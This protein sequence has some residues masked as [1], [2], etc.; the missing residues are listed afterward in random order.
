M[1]YLSVEGLSKTFGSKL[2][3][4]KINFGIN[5]GQRVALVA[6]NGAGKSTLLKIIMGKEIPDEGTVTLRK[7]ISLAYLDQQPQFIE[8]SSIADAIYQTNNPVLTAVKNYELAIAAYE[9]DSGPANEKKLELASAE[10]ENLNAWDHDARVKEVLSRLNIN[11][12]ERKISSLSGGQKKRLALA[13]LLI[14]TPDLLILDEPTNHLDIEMIEWLEN[15]LVSNNMTLLLVTHDRYFLDAVC[16]EIIEI[17]NGKLYHYAGDFQ[18]YVEKKAEREQ[19]ESSEI[20]KAKNLYKRE[21]EWIRKMPRARTVKSKSR[22]DA[23]DDIKEKAFSKRKE[24]K[25]TL[26]VKMSRLGSKIIELTKVHKKYG[27]Q[28]IV[29][30]FSYVF[31]TGEKI[32]IIGKNGVGKTTLI[33]MITGVEQVDSGKIQTGDTIIF[34]H[35]SQDG[36]K[37]PEDKRVIEVIKDIADYIPLS[38]GS[39]LSAAQILQR[40]MFPPDVQYSFVSKLSGGEKRRLYLLTVLMK[41]PN[42]LILDEPTNDLDLMTMNTLED[43]LLGFKGC[44]LIVTHDRFFMDKLVDHLFVFEGDGVIRDFPGHYTDYREKLAEEKKA[45]K[46]LPKE[47]EKPIIVETP[48]LAPQPEKPKRQLSFKEKHEFE[49][50]EKELPKLE[51]EKKSLDEK[52]AIGS[53][54]SNDIMQWSTRIGIVIQEI[55]EKTMRWLELS[56]LI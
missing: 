9:Q 31:K 25:I 15:Y 52:L 6:R 56:E 23:F 32:G 21:L 54:N 8:T 34:G 1:N 17:D 46:N 53:S 7:D 35:Y 22:I 44:V 4:N 26:D 13:T 49:Q 5:H 19:I 50:L 41:N 16:S 30:D 42:F 24:E 28:K 2:L 10:M 40:F 38:D 14:N 55:E 48:T 37:L 39:T 27:E 12:P 47:I 36:I 20:D 43:F 29:D 3:F 18:Y 33:K 51:A 45:D 11:Y